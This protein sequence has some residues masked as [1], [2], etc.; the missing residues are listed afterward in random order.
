M[1]GDGNKVASVYKGIYFLAFPL[2]IDLFD[3]WSCKTF[4]STKRARLHIAIL[5]M[6]VFAGIFALVVPFAAITTS[7][8]FFIDHVSNNSYWWISFVVLLIFSL[9]YVLKILFY[10]ILET[11]SLDG[12]IKT[13]KRPITQKIEN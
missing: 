2:S 5:V 12:K 3:M 1:F 13:E 4:V 7:N 10:D 9:A 11:F 8:Q 6:S